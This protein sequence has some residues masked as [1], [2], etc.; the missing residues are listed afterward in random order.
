MAEII[1]FKKI[2]GHLARG[3]PAIF[4]WLTVPFHRFVFITVPDS[5]SRNI[6][7]VVIVRRGAVGVVGIWK[8]WDSWV[9][10]G[11]NGVSLQAT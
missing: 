4:F 11:A 9:K 1:V 6:P 3:S 8:G 7:E 5:K 10:G 2:L